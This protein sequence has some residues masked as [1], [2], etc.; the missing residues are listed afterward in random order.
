VLLDRV[1]VSLGALG[2][3][4]PQVVNCDAAEVAA[5]PD[6][7]IP[8]QEAP[9]RIAMAEQDRRPG[10]ALVDIMHLPGVTGEPALPKRVQGGS[11][12]KSIFIGFSC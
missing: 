3:P 4:E 10:A 7:D 6:D 8:V 9:R 5:Q 12:V 11:G 2:Q 1:T